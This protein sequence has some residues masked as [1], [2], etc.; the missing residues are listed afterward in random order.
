MRNERRRSS[1]FQVYVEGT[2]T[3]ADSEGLGH[4]IDMSR[5]GMLLSTT[6]PLEL[7]QTF[8]F[9]APL[10]NLLD[11]DEAELGV[12]ARV[13]AERV[14]SSMGVRV[15]QYRCEFDEPSRFRNSDVIE[16]L[17]ATHG[18]ELPRPTMPPPPTDAPRS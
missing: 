7:D 5:H 16:R 3:T 4:I 1:R 13:V 2:L 18:G 17:I 15:T 12:D 14:E 9:S 11:D 8:S 6:V 10:G